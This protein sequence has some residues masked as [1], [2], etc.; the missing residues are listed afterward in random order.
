MERYIAPLVE[1]FS[2]EKF[3][4]LS[5]P[6]Q[7]G[8]TTLAKKWLEAEKG[9]YVNWDDASDRKLILEQTFLS[10]TEGKASS[11]FV[12]DELHKYARWKSWLKGLYD[13]HAHHLKVVVT[14]SAKLDVYKRHGDSLFGRY[15]SLRLHPLS[16]GELSHGKLVP[17]PTDWLHLGEKSVPFTLWE[18][19]KNRGGFPEPFYKDNA[20]Q[21]R[22]WSLRRRELL[23]QQDLRDISEIKT[24]SLVE[25]LTLLLPSRIASPLS[26]NSLREELQV[27]FD[28]LKSW[29]L[30]LEKLYWCYRISPYSKNIS[31]SL[32][33]EQ[34]LY[35]WDWSG[36]PE[37]PAR[38]ENMVA[39]HLL[40]AVQAWTDV[41]YGEF[42]LHYF[43]DL[44]KREVD[45]V[46]T[47]NRIPVVLIECK[48]NSQSLSPELHYLN[49][50]LKKE[51]R[52][53]LPM[54]Q[55]VDEQNVD[56]VHRNSRI[57]TAANYLATLV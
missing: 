57:V 43:R 29:L 50:H 11:A 14:G 33:K 37:A 31:R 46:I 42:N 16:I 12:F 21:H 32:R 13:K 54:I 30:V 56:F 51:N 38:F 4:L 10:Q 9:S 5:G 2:R 8:K 40:K 15:E 24:L 48:V 39:S 28:T 41:G 55:L 3:V 35:F 52:H 27:A 20:L 23:I 7:V 22:R 36:V 18:Q 6:R 19:L 44:E 26:L 49:A 25:H 53:D 45:F 34:K 17:P 47:Q 1:E